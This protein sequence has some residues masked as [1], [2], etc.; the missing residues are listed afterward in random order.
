VRFEVLTAEVIT[1]AVCYVTLCRRCEK[2]GVRLDLNMN[3]LYSSET[4]TIY[5]SIRRYIPEDLTLHPYCHSRSGLSTGIRTGY[6]L[7]RY[8]DTQNYLQ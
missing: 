8:G 6:V 3:A 5:Q 2:C 7:F 4:S 1:I